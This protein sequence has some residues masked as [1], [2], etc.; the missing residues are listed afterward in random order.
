MSN[1]SK[2]TESLQDSLHDYLKAINISIAIKVLL[3]FAGFVGGVTGFLLLK[4]G[5][6]SF[7]YLSVITV[8]N[9]C[10]GIYNLFVWQRL[11]QQRYITKLRLSYLE[12]R[13]NHIST[14]R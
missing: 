2:D 10:S 6:T 8:I 11:K 14:L 4:Q 5:K 3:I 9:F 1:L 13:D 12:M 7:N